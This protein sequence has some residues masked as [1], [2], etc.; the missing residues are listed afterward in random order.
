[1][2]KYFPANVIYLCQWGS[3]AQS[4]C[5]ALRWEGGQRGLYAPAS[6]S[7]HNPDVSVA[8]AARCTAPCGK[9]YIFSN[10]LEGLLDT[11][12]VSRSCD[13]HRH[14]LFGVLFLLARSVVNTHLTTDGR[15]SDT[16]EHK[17]LG[18]NK[19]FFS[20]VWG[21]GV[22]FSRACKDSLSGAR[23][24]SSHERCPAKLHTCV[25]LQSS[26]PFST[27]ACQHRR[28]KL[29]EKRAVLDTRDSRKRKK[30]KSRENRRGDVS[31]SLA[32]WHLMPLCLWCRLHRVLQ[33]AVI[34]LQNN[35]S[36]EPV[37]AMGCL[38]CL[39]S[40]LFQNKCWVQLSL[41]CKE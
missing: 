11:F 2:L 37:S 32:L 7:I 33:Q 22:S 18:G 28:L 13:F 29:R 26:A 14:I 6:H 36:D 34:Y 4:F 39:K 16:F 30:K 17:T 9:A 1:M 31:V 10:L 38:L 5:K 19:S 3:I 21:W 27:A 15:D 41:D 20:L 8:E 24:S 23:E 12:K 25:F 40:V 35:Q